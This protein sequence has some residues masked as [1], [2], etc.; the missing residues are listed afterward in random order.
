MYS[1]WWV[2]LSPE[3]CRVKHL[4]RINRNCCISLELFSLYLFPYFHWFDNQKK[5]STVTTKK[6]WIIHWQWRTEEIHS[7]PQHKISCCVVKFSIELN[8]KVFT[9]HIQ[10]QRTNDQ[11]ISGTPFP[12]PVIFHYVKLSCFPFSYSFNSYYRNITVLSGKDIITGKNNEEG[13]NWQDLHG[14]KSNAE[15]TKNHPSVCSFIS[16]CKTSPWWNTST[17]QSGRAEVKLT[18]Y[19]HLLERDDVL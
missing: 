5:L 13:K 15:N 7:F 6:M 4:R 8:K 3:T 12:I 11:N 9:S 2:G 19:R 1:W 18:T 14:L 16:F 10:L 17:W